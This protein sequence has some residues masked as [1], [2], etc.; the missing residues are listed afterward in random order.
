MLDNYN[1]YHLINTAITADEQEHLLLSAQLVDDENDVTAV[2]LYLEDVLDVS[3]LLVHTLNMNKHLAKSQDVSFTSAIELE[4]QKIAKKEQIEQIVSDDNNNIDENNVITEAGKATKLPDINAV[5]AAIESPVE[6][7]TQSTIDIDEHNS[8]DESVEERT[9]EAKPAIEERNLNTDEETP[10][11]G[12]E[13][14]SEYVDVTEDETD[15]ILSQQKILEQAR[16][17]NKAVVTNM[18]NQPQGEA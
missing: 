10:A 17:T 12:I 5:H 16:Q 1:R 6:V 13:L 14:V 18:F 2:E 7:S 15:K 9:I 8:V 11:M 4:K 3:R